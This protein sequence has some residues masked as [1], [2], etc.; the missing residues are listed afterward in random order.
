M[1]RY[2]HTQP[3]QA[4]HKIGTWLLFV[5]GSIAFGLAFTYSIDTQIDNQSIMLCN[6]AKK[7][8]N[9]EYLEKC[10][11]F[12]NSGDIECLQNIN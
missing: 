11:C 3:R 4:T 7:S 5:I 12:Y 9:V 10:Q 2:T 8:G 1:Q 6:S